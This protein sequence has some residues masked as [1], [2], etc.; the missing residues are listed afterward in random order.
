MR[1]VFTLILLFTSF[2]LIA[3]TTYHVRK[4]G[5]DGNDGLSW[6][7]A[8]LT[9]QKALSAATHHG[10]KVV[11]AQGTYYPDEGP[12]ITDN[13]REQSFVIPFGVAVHGG[14]EGVEGDYTQDWKL[15]TTTL[16]GN[17][18][19]DAST[20]N[21]TRNIVVIE[22]LTTAQY[23]TAE[24]TI[25]GFNIING[26]AQGAPNNTTGGGIQVRLIQPGFN[27][28][29]INKVTISNC[30]FRQNNA[31][32][33]S[34]L[35]LS[36]SKYVYVAIFLCEFVNNRSESGG[37]A[38]HNAGFSPTIGDCKFLDNGTLTSEGTIYN[39]GNM[40]FPKIANPAIAN[41]YFSN[42]FGYSVI[43]NNGRN[44]GDASP[45]FF[46]CAFA[47]NNEQV[48]IASFGIEGK[49]S[50]TFR[51]CSFSNTALPNNPSLSRPVVYT[52]GFNGIAEPK[53][54]NCIVWN[55]S[56]N[57]ITQF[58]PA[59]TTTSN[60][61]VKG[62]FLNGSWASNY[63]VDGGNNSDEDPAFVDAA[64]GNIRLQTCSPAID[65]GDNSVIR[66]TPDPD[67][68]NRVING[69]IDIGAYEYGG[70]PDNF[71]PTVKTKNISI[72]LD[73]SGVA[74]ITANSVNDGS[75][76]ACGIKSMNVKPSAFSCN[77]IGPQTVVLT[78]VDNN[79][80]EASGTATVTIVDNT[81]PQARCRNLTIQLDANGNASLTTV[82][83]DNGSTD[84]CGIKMRT[85]SN[86]NFTCNDIG[87]NE[88]NLYVTDN[89]DNVSNCTAI[90]TVE[91]KIEPVALCKNI[92]VY[93]NAQGTATISAAD[94]NN[95]SSDACGIKSYQLSKT[96]FDCSSKG[97][98]TVLLTVTDNNDN[99]ATCSSVVTVLD[100]IAPV[101]NSVSADPSIIWPPDLKM[102]T[103]TVSAIVSDNCP[104]T[105]WRISGVAI[106]EGAGINSN[107]PDW[108]ITSSSTV[109]VR[110]EIPKKSVRRLYRL[111]ITATDAAGNTSMLT[112]DVI[113]SKNPP[114]STKTITKV[115]S[116]P[117]VGNAKESIS[118]DVMVFP[119][120]SSKDFAIRLTPHKK[121]GI[122]MIQVADI[123]GRIIET[124]KVNGN[125][126][127]RI[128]EQ[129]QPGAYFV[130]VTEGD[131]KTYILK[132]IK[133]H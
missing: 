112:T 74:T 67:G 71:P 113:I 12:G 50:P 122:V 117:V 103:V 62:S 123:Y 25:D 104:G 106:V 85:L 43:Y 107:D 124:R 15:F 132:L 70:G 68:N 126:I 81:A 95:G 130:R 89:N 109:N 77:T 84:A 59:V 8:F 57:Q 22:S 127:I 44:G 47:N 40:T 26:N 76:D 11:V 133:T 31:G 35:N 102:K 92:T 93:L 49:S 128:G 17:I 16:N 101:I 9:L 97:A 119:N 4:T 56:S 33:I 52:D 14:Y 38:I 39:T 83:V 72:S 120:P 66:V 91:D 1:Q 108:E 6:N 60:S 118:T 80:N 53:L 27:V 45:D 2:N 96:T 30:S 94:V 37:S 3:Q 99:T 10:D 105:T 114:A 69:I 78:V 41:C 55:N 18:Q 46:N 23:P 48:T 54:D 79:D 121:L 36:S 20:F 131:K 90:I 5:D 129:Y 100:N 75:S 82:Q 34:L 24:N 28:S 64:E 61:I 115:N 51:N 110:A 87:T 21:N 63:G 111:T 98:N 13:D 42:N 116:N 32:A 88:V 7:T 29:V 65:A 73:A 125:S 86:Y 19:N 58:H